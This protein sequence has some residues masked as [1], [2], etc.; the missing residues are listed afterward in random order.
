MITGGDRNLSIRNGA[1]QVDRHSMS[2]QMSIDHKHVYLVTERIIEIVAGIF[3]QYVL[4]NS[5]FFR[6]RIE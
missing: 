1:L 6:V 5:G 2:R 4:S 3:S